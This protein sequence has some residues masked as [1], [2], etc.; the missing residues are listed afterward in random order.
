MAVLDDAF[1]ETAIDCFQVIVMFLGVSGL[2]LFI[3]P[4]LAV[5]VVAII[6]I[7]LAMRVFFVRTARDLKRIEST[8]RSPLFSHV[9][10]TMA[11]LPVI[12]TDAS[13]TTRFQEVFA[14][15]LDMLAMVFVSGTAFGAV[16]SRDQITPSTAAL[17]L[18]K[19]VCVCGVGM[20]V[21]VCVCVCVWVSRCFCFGV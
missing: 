4:F 11:G 20:C 12:R 15:R 10:N 13:H 14:L 2:V 16:F 7:M 8:D 3:I 19:G 1:P 17:A 21:C 6:G 9:F 18:G 5:L